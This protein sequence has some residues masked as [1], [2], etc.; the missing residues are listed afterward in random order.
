MAFGLDDPADTGILCGFIHSIAGLVYNRCRHCSFSINPVF[1]NPIMDFRG[2]IEIRVRI[3]S[4]IFPM[5]RFMLNRKTLSFTYLIIKE[6]VWGR[7]KSN[8]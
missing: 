5:L 6:K 7:W 8:S 4:L 2:S 1:M 3:Y